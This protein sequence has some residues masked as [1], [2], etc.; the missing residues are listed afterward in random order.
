MLVEDIMSKDIHYIKVPGSRSTA[1]DLMRKKKISGVPVVKKGTKKLVGIVTRSDLIEDPEEE[2]IAL[3][4]TRDP[5]TTT[6]DEDVREVAKKMVEHNIRRVPVVED[7]E[8][9]GIVTAYDLIT[10]ALSTIEIGEPVEKYMLKN[11]PTTWEGTPLNVAFEIMRHFNLKVLLA[12]DKDGKLSGILTE[13][14]FI[15]ESEVVSERI[16]HSASVGTEGDKWTWDSKSVLYVTKNQLKVSNKQVR[17][18]ATTKV[19]T[20]TQ[21]TS[22]TECA[23]KMKQKNIE[24][25]PVIDAE[26]E[27]VG[28]LRAS[29]LIKA[30]ND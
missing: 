3:I 27:L 4:M 26:G 29:D 19:V 16:V 10:E 28:L 2:Q 5:I 25:L 12:L 18:V 13:T 30:F 22:V 1:L 14:D 23:K 21:R 15:N 17:D 8:L 6:P 20:V 9:V 11:I 7:G 24:Q